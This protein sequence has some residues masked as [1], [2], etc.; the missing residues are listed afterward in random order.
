MRGG[1]PGGRTGV[2]GERS[3]RLLWLGQLVSHVGDALIPVA[4]AFAVLEVTGSASDLGVVLACFMAS[5]VVF[6]IAGGVWA[7]RLPR[8]L[9][10]IAADVVR[11]ATQIAIAVAFFTGTIELWHL[12]AQAL[13]MGSSAAFFGPAS[14]GLVK[15]LVSPGGLQQANALISLSHSTVAVAG[16]ALAGLLVTAFGFG[17]VFAID[18]AT[19]VVSAAFL[20]AMRLPAPVQRQERRSFVAEVVDGVREVRRRTWLWTAFLAFSASNVA[21]AI[22]FV[23]APTIVEAEIGGPS[24]WGL[25]VTGGSIGSVLGAVVA[26]RWRPGR[27]LVPAFL[28]MSC[29]PLQLLALTPPLPAAGLMAG[30]ALAFFA[31][32]VGN[33]LWDTMV[34][35]HVPAEAISRVSSI[36]SLISFV[37]MPLG[38]LIAGPLGEAFGYDTTLVAAAALIAVANLAVLAVPGL[39]NLRRAEAGPA[40]AP[41]A[42]VD[43]PYRTPAA[44]G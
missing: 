22:Y 3:F 2:L 18:A 25:I 21:L 26:L 38:F 40:P 35:Q 13:L 41:G 14:T 32:A 34:Q 36:D 39:R 9:V 28:L 17:I 43:D 19:Y 42:G 37:F 33:A 10:M 5:R 20:L 44:V 7:D 6:I 15:D 11:A 4:L 8:Q 30:A 16:P 1:V 29:V 27:P 31:I 24:A 12:A 23:L